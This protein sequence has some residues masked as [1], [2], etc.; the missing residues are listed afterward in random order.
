MALGKPAWLEA[1]ETLQKILRKTNPFLRDNSELCAKAF[2]KQSDAQMH[3]PA[4]IGLFLIL[5]Y[6]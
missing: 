2:I 1:R 4:K 3:L 5:I 6:L